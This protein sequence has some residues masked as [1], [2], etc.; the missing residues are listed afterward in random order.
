VL[1]DVH[2]TEAR[3]RELTRSGR[4]FVLAEQF[5]VQGMAKLIHTKISEAQPSIYTTQSLLELARIIFT[6]P[7]ASDG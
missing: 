7:V 3:S 4:L 5:Q 6:R 1:K 2:T